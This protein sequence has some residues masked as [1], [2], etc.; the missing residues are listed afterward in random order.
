[1]EYSSETDKDLRSDTAVGFESNNRPVGYGK[2]CALVWSCVEDR[3]W[4]CV[5]KGDIARGKNG[6]QKGYQ[7][8]RLKKKA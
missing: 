1:M 8:S 6:G 5:E 4:S 2:R 3:G 7:T